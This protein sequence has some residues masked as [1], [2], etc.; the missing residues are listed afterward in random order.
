MDKVMIWR[1]YCTPTIFA[2]NST[3]GSWLC[4]TYSPVVLALDVVSPA[5]MV[6]IIKRVQAIVSRCQRPEIR[7]RKRRMP[8]NSTCNIQLRRQTGVESLPSCRSLAL[9]SDA[10]GKCV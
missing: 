2:R 7:Q 9:S 1:R 4:V 5:I 3:L 10:I 6:E 8:G